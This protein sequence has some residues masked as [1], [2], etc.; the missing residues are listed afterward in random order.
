MTHRVWLL[1]IE[2]GEKAKEQGARKA[3]EQGERGKTNRKRKGKGEDREGEGRQGGR[4]R[5]SRNPFHTARSL[6]RE[7]QGFGFRV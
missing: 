4:G 5:G 1:I 3:K 2:F 7:D 6:G